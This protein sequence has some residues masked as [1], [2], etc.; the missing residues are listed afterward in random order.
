[1]RFK[2]D[3]HLPLEIKDL[4]A[5]HRHDAMTVAEQGMAGAVDP[6]QVKGSKGDRLLFH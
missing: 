4:F 5:Q 2:I 6:G 1:M 3:E